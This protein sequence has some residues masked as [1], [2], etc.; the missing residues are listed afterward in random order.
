MA[1]MST[2]LMFTGVTSKN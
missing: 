1:D 2:L